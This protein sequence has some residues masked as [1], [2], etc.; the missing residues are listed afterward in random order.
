MP[1]KKV[2]DGDGVIDLFF[3]VAPPTPF[4]ARALPCPAARAMARLRQACSCPRATLGG[5]LEVE[6]SSSSGGRGRWE[7]GLGPCLPPCLSLAGGPE[8]QWPPLAGGERR[9]KR[10][11]GHGRPGRASYRRACQGESESGGLS[12]CSCSWR[13]CPGKT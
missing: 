13:S 8:P 10:R 1:N 2:R 12:V 9:L 3:G 5:S 11:A 6:A 7:L 4:S